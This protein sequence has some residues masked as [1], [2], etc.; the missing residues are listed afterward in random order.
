MKRID[1]ASCKLTTAIY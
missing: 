1:R